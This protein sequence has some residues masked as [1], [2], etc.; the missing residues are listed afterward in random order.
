[1]E[2]EVYVI[3]GAS[4]GIGQASALRLA[5]PGRRFVLIARRKERLDSLAAE[6]EALGCQVFVATCDVRNRSE[7][8]AA[9][10]Q[11]PTEFQ[12]IRVLLNNAGLASGL[13]PIQ[14]GHFDD[15]EKMIDTNVKGLLYVTE[16]VLPLMKGVEGAQ[17]VNVGSVAGK[18]V[19]PNGNVY[20]ASKHAVDALS[21]AIRMDLLPEGIRVSTVSPGLVET[22]FSIVRFHGDEAK[23]AQVYKGMQAL[24]PADVADAIA[25]ITE[26][27]YRITIADIV[28]F[29]SAQASSRDVKRS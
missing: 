2:N 16:A 21:R 26:A 10:A 1:M 18:E 19:Y 27:P 17:I 14:K 5:V 28:I 3:T 20:C 4:S 13:D 6:L 25:Y 11:L 7:V 9:I 22:E 8:M 12:H 15:W 29:P 24:T 23:A